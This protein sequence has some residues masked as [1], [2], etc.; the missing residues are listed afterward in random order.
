MSR[1]Q[2]IFQDMQTKMFAHLSIFRH[3]SVL[4]T[5]LRTQAGRKEKEVFYN[6]ICRLS[7]NSS[8]RTVSAAS[9]GG[10]GRYEADLAPVRSD[11]GKNSTGRH[12]PYEP[13][14]ACAFLRHY[15]R[16]YEQSNAS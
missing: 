10:V 12:A 5:L 15:A 6:G 14:V 8:C 13:L 4:P 7:Y 9:S 16:P 3:L 11:R 1:S 2:E